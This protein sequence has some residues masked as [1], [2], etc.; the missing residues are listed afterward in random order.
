MICEMGDGGAMADVELKLKTNKAVAEKEC[1]SDRNDAIFEH[2]V[3]TIRIIAC[4]MTSSYL[5][6]SLSSHH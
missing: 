5:L 6:V 3:L 4:S 2:L 1:S